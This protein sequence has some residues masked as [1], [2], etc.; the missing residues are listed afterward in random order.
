MISV[1]GLVK[2]SYNLH[3]GS[4][5]TF[6]F[7]SFKQF[8]LASATLFPLIYSMVTKIF[9][10]AERLIIINYL[11]PQSSCPAQK[12]D[13]HSGCPVPPKLLSLP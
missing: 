2:V 7:Q 6:F 4:K 12:P 9:K 3:V 10:I 1:S 11:Y 13:A 5:I 8:N